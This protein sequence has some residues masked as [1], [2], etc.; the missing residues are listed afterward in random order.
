MAMNSSS[1]ENGWTELRSSNLD[2]A[3]KI[4]REM[5]RQDPNLAEALHGIGLVAL[6]TGNYEIAVSLLE[7]ALK[8]QPRQVG[9]LA[10]YSY[11]L[12]R[13]GRLEPAVAALSSALEIDP[14]NS[15][16]WRASGELMISRGD[17][18]NAVQQQH[19]SIALEQTNIDTYAQLGLLVRDGYYSYSQQELDVMS[20]LAEDKSVT[21]RAKAMLKFSL[22]YHFDSI[23][24]PDQA[25]GSFIQANALRLRAAVPS[26]QFN[27]KLHA[28]FV[29]EIE[30]TFTA[31]FI[32]KHVTGANESELPVFIVGMMR[33]GTTLIEQIIA[34]H[35][36]ATAAGELNHLYSM[37]TQGLGMLANGQS[38][39]GALKILRTAALT[40]MANDYLALLQQR[41]PDAKRI[42]DKMPTNFQFLGLVWML[43]P[44]ARVI[45]V[46][47]DPM[48]TCVSCYCNNLQAGWTC[49]LEDLGYFYRNYRRIMRL[50]KSVLP[51][52]MLHVK[53]E[54][55]VSKPNADIRRI[56]EFCGLPWRDECLEFHK[57]QDSVSTASKLQVRKAVH[58]GR[59]ARW[60]RYE[61]H[62]EPLR[63][64]LGDENN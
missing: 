44:N 32:D 18:E 45:H 24:D 64:A 49:D 62:L 55:L 50:W 54:D 30:E 46:E 63:C 28:E 29:D 39:P 38:Y 23:D 36:D 3:L 16:L 19:K 13:V 21:E 27:P 11:C 60:K 8:G 15:Q 51:M 5:L 9:C 4:F 22:G 37:A 61:K 2:A 59:V 48:D 20:R 57:S 58:G 42:T 26:E 43:F 40:P 14:E 6:R 12:R 10:D 25:F 33:S 56:I 7:R 1:L 35:P 47:R 34:S 17:T 41:N 31:E 53:Y 52:Q